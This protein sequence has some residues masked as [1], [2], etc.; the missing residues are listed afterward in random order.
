M[1]EYVQLL[2]LF[3]SSTTVQ[4]KWQRGKREDGRQARLSP[5]WSPVI[6]SYTRPARDNANDTISNSGSAMVVYFSDHGL[7]RR[8]PQLSSVFNVV[9]WRAP[10][11]IGSRVSTS[12]EMWGMTSSR[13]RSIRFVIK[14]RHRQHELDFTTV[15]CDFSNF[16]IQGIVV[17]WCVLVVESRWPR[18]LRHA[19]RVCI[20]LKSSEAGNRR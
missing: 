4:V 7:S 13:R 8:V 1:I 3:S 17:G 2:H 6:H 15:C 20:L 16:V 11:I 12:G 19:G 9:G 5:R 18:P 10:T 14:K